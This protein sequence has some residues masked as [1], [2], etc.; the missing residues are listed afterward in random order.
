MVQDESDEDDPVNSQELPFFIEGRTNLRLA[1]D[2]S[3]SESSGTVVLRL[4]D[5]PLWAVLASLKRSELV[6]EGARSNAST[7]PTSH[8]VY[9]S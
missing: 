9:F 7:P 1:F 2:M 8:Q 4:R 5:Q 3:E 6:K